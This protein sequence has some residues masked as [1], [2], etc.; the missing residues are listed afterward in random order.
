MAIDVGWIADSGGGSVA[1]VLYSSWQVVDYVQYSIRLQE[2]IRQH[3]KW[4]I[5]VVWNW[6][7]FNQYKTQG[8]ASI[9]QI[10]FL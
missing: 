5:L 8:Y 4:E 3:W 9:R 2:E 1:A 10:I 6:C 7:R